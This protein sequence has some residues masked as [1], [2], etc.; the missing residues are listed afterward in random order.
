VQEGAPCLTVIVWLRESLTQAR[1]TLA[2]DF[3]SQQASEALSDPSRQ[4]NVASM[5]A[6]PQLCA[7]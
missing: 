5:V 4:T 1:N 7:V 3:M 2:I 6:A